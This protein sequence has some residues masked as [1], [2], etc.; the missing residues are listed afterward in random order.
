MGNNSINII[1]YRTA[2]SVLLRND[3]IISSTVYKRIDCFG[4]CLI[5]KVSSFAIK[6]LF[7]RLLG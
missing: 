5:R 6:K 3:R 2:D 7:A 4:D 1:D